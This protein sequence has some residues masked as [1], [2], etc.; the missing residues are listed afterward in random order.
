VP[1]VTEAPK[2]SELLN[3]SSHAH[4]FRFLRMHNSASPRLDVRGLP[5]LQNV[6]RRIVFGEGPSRHAFREYS[7]DHATAFPVRVP[8]NS[9]L[10][11]GKYSFGRDSI[12][13]GVSSEHLRHVIIVTKKVGNPE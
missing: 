7:F 8:K 5:T 1:I 4:W 3:F 11:W 6:D 2:L 13:V 12:F 10:S 9:I